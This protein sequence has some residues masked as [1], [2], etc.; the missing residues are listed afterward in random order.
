MLFEVSYDEFVL[1]FGKDLQGKEEGGVAFDMA[2]GRNRVKPPRI[3]PPANMT[4]E[5]VC[6]VLQVKVA[7]EFAAVHK[8]FRDI[9][10]DCSGAIGP[11]EVRR[12]LER[13]TLYMSEAEFARLWA[14]L[15]IDKS[16]EISFDEFVLFFH[17]LATCGAPQPVSPRPPSGPGPREQRPS[18]RKPRPSTALTSRPATARHSQAMSMKGPR[19]NPSGN[20]PDRSRVNSRN[21]GQMRGEAPGLAIVGRAPSRASTA[22]A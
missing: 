2:E 8:A 9:D 1:F 10:Y 15:D 22:R 14:A 5:E 16:G 12:L 7:A 4:M 18:S 3:R 11:E 13:Y 17:G 19:G 20:P 6:E 21:R